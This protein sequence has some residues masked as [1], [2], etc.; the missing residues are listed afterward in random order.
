MDA[1]TKIFNITMKNDLI[2]KFGNNLSKDVRLSNYSWFNLGGTAE[3][4][5]KAKDKNQLM[6]FL[7]YAKKDNLK[8]T[9]VGAGS[10]TLFRD[11]GVKGA[12][13]KLGKI[14]SYTKL[15]NENIIETGAGTLD[16][17][18]ANFAK[19]NDL[20][21]F[22]FLSCIPGSIGGAIIMNSGCYDN[23]IS[24]ILLSLKATWAR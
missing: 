2:K 7:H 16:R 11:K 12:V 5:Y 20:S 14:F 23:D 18:L 24:K 9:I 17:N 1:K 15:V 6:E 13:I 21:N 3:Y 10:N 22:E 8:T 19:D 4:F